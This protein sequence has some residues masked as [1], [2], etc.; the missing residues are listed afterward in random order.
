MHLHSLNSTDNIEIILPRDSLPTKMIQGSIELMK[1][2]LQSLNAYKHNITIYT[3]Q[4]YDQVFS[5][6]G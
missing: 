3:N 5:K 4:F 1:E 2:W 6:F